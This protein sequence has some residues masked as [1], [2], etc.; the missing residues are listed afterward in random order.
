[1][2]SRRTSLA[3]DMNEPDTETFC[4]AHPQNPALYFC[5]HSWK[6]ICEECGNQ[7]EQEGHLVLNLSVAMEETMSEVKNKQRQLNTKR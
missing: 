6:P 7:E 4:H 3:S 5:T 2:D 1:M